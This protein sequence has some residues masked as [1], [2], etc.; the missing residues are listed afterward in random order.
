MTVSII[1]GSGTASISD[2]GDPISARAAFN[3]LSARLARG[4]ARGLH[5]G[6]SILARALA[7]RAERSCKD[8]LRAAIHA[9]GHRMLALLK[10]PEFRKELLQVMMLAVMLGQW[11]WAPP[12]ALV[13]IG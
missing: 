11:S 6:W 5:R 13:I 7:A 9:L 12:A 2:P 8:S 3:V 4:V 1:A 10:D